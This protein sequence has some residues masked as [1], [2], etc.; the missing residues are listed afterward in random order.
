MYQSIAAALFQSRTRTGVLD[1]LFCQEAS[2][3]VSELARRVGVTPRSVAMEVH[4]LRSAGLVTIEAVGAADLVRPNLQHPAAPHL[5]G[6]LRARATP[7]AAP[8]RERRL[9]DSLIAWGAPLSGERAEAHE[10]LEDTLLAGLAAARRDGTILRVLPVVLARNLSQLDWRALRE[11]ARARKLKAEL[12]MLVEL[13]ADLL[14]RPELR[15]EVADLRDRRRRGA[16]FFPEIHSDFERRLAGLRT[17]ASARRWGFRMNMSE[18][19]FRSTLER[20]RA[21]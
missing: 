19:S 15:R 6:L 4:N 2:A 7:P 3:T 16:R 18:E 17:P 14:D 1:L 20:H 21:P 8:G 11:G 10:G 13:T 9:R 5:R 12:G